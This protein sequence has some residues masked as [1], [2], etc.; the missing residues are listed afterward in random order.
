[1]GACQGT[2]SVF[3]L[4]VR[5]VA[6]IAERNLICLRDAGSSPCILPFAAQGGEEQGGMRFYKASQMKSVKDITAFTKM[7]YRQ[8]GQASAAELLKKDLRAELEEKERKHLKSKEE[9]LGESEVER[10][11]SVLMA[12]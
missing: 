9:F 8:E 12:T 2:R 10:D 1:M 5:R 3:V 4:G 7:K 6:H 11:L